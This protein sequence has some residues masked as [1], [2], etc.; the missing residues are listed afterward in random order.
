MSP[1]QT[2]I[3][4]PSMAEVI[5]QAIETRLADLH[6]GLPAKVISFDPDKGTCVVQPLL[7]RFI[8]DENGDEQ[9][10]RLPQISNVPVRYPGGGGWFLIF[11]LKP[12]NI[13]FLSFIERSIDTWMEADAGADVDPVH[14]RKHDLSDAICIPSMRPRTK[15]IKDLASLGDNCRLGFEGGDPAIV[16]KPDG[17]IEIGEGA[18]EALVLGGVL[19]TNLSAITV[20]TAFGPSGTPINAGSFG[21]HLSEKGK[22]K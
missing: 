8:I 4:T 2:P 11:P 22:V 1:R 21:D 17:T 20:P 13:V 12:D 15:P 14:T 6:T 3:L 19:N 5:V 10:E 18:T 16:L 9:E 7:L